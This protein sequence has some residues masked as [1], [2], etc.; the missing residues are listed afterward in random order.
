MKRLKIYFLITITL[1]INS[2]GI[3]EEIGNQSNP[4]S[5][6][7]SEKVTLNELLEN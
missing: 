5:S 2:C 6:T 7:Y 3:N 1:I 4:K